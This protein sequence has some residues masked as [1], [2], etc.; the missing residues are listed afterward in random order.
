MHVA[1]QFDAKK[2]ALIQL[3][4]NQYQPIQFLVKNAPPTD[5]IQFYYILICINLP[6]NK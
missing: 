1:L 6:F 5:I 4:L 3:Y 2:H